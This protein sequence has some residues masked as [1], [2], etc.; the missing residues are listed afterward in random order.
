MDSSARLLLTITS[1]E[2]AIDFFEFLECVI[3]PYCQY[4]A[5]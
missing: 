1:H 4:R 5:L 2:A 3:Y